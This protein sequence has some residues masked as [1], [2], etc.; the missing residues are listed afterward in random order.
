MIIIVSMDVKTFEKLIK[1]R[2]ELGCTCKKSVGKIAVF[3]AHAV[4]MCMPA[5]VVKQLS[6]SI[7]CEL[8]QLAFARIILFSGHGEDAQLAALEQ[9]VEE[10]NHSYP[11]TS[12]C[13]A[14]AS[15]IGE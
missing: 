13:P 7:L 5:L 1:T 15:N 6:L 10:F 4:T 3:F 12:L 9:A 14:E 11:H 2:I 8:Y